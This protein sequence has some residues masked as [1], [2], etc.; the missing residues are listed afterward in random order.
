ML[1]TTLVLSTD[2]AADKT[3]LPRAKLLVAALKDLADEELSHAAA[4]E[5][6]AA[7]ASD[8][9]PNAASDGDAAAASDAA[10][11]AAALEMSEWRKST[12]LCITLKAADIGHLIEGREVHVRWVR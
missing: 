1:I 3:T 5:S 8:A 7:A 6:S 2:I 11:D 4:E 12:L 10:A 9:A